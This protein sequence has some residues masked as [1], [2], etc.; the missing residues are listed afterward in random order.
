[1]RTPGWRPPSS[2]P[3]EN[4]TLFPFKTHGVLLITAV[5]PDWEAGRKKLLKAPALRE[6]QEA[7]SEGGEGCLQAWPGICF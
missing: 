4:L 3:V 7:G 2:L 1:M 5:A 6:R